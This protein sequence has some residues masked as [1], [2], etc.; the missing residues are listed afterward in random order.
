MKIILSFSLAMLAAGLLPAAE[1]NPKADVTAAAN[2]LGSQTNYSWHTTVEVPGDSP[3]KPGP[4]DGKTEQNG[5]TTVT[6]N[7]GDNPTDAVIH[8]T[9]AAIKTADNGWQS[10]A[11]ATADNGGGF[12][13][14]VMIARM[15][16]DY[17]TPAVEAAALAEQTKSLTA[18]ANGITGDLTEEGAK[19]L[20]AMR[21][22]PNGGPS[23]SNAKGTITFWITDGKLTKYQFHTTGTISFN[24]D[25]HDMDRTTTTE[26]KDV[27]ATTIQVPDEAK[28][29]LE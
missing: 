19:A 12:N 5:Y 28:K 10:T 22:G 13:P 27:N 17:R 20:M 9:K 23:I 1:S 15:A 11:E 29:K 26:I 7:F 4:T 16:K 3:F 2:A 25:D 21:G 18:G 24:G 6:F 14:A 8:G